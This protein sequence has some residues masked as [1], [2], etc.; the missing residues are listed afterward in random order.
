MLI[1][2]MCEVVSGVSQTE[3]EATLGSKITVHICIMYVYIYVYTQIY[4]RV[5]YPVIDLRMPVFNW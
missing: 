5:T 2:V 4:C 1:G 3:R